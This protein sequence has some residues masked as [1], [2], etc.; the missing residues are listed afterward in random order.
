MVI[1]TFKKEIVGK[2]NKK[3]YRTI[4]VIKCEECG[5]KKE[6]RLDVVKKGRLNRNNEIDLC[7]SCSQLL[8]YSGKRPRGEKNKNFKHGLHNGG[9]R[10]LTVDNGRKCFEHQ[11][12][13]EQH[14]GRKLNKE[15]RIHHIDFNKINN[16][17]FNLYLF[18]LNGDHSR[19]H[20]Q[21]EK[22]GYD[23][24]GEKIWFDRV[25]KK[26]VLNETV[27]FLDHNEYNLNVNKLYKI[28]YKR[29]NSYY[30][31]YA[32]K[33]NNGKWITKNYHVALMELKIGRKLFIN[34]CVHHIDGDTLNNYINNLLLLTRSEHT[35]SHISL[36]NCVADLYKQDIVGFNRS[37]GQYFV[38]EK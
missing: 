16:E 9:Y 1:R 18:N 17:I 7:L 24:F 15:E 8:K 30:Y 32:Y 31:K 27:S 26:Y 14:L 38:I 10:L 12:V 36:Q 23:L 2:N 11:Y 28:H 20:H 22:I 25:N 21:T 6:S 19:C 37:N 5:V 13:M 33:N 29:T 3:Q 35:S 4:C 34:E